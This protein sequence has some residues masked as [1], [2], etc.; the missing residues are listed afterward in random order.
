MKKLILPLIIVLSFPSFAQKVDCE[1]ALFDANK[2]YEIGA[3]QEAIDLITPCLTKHK[4]DKNEIF[5]AHRLLTLCHIA[6]NEK[7]KAI[8]SAKL[9]LQENP[10]YR[11]YPYSDPKSLTKL[12]DEFDV[13]NK[14]D[15]GLT[16]GLYNHNLLIIKSYAADKT[17]S[18][19]NDKLGFSAGLF[20]EYHI[21]EN[22]AVNFAPNI[23]SVR[24]E[25]VLDTIAGSRKEFSE[26]LTTFELPIAFRSYFNI[27]KTQFYAQVG[28]QSL[29]VVQSFADVQS[30]NLRDGS[31]FQ[32]ST[33]TTDY[34]NDNILGINAA[35][36]LT[37]RL[38]EGFFNVGLSYKYFLNNVVNEDKRYDNVDFILSSQ[39]I[40]SDFNF[41]S[42]GLMFSYQFPIIYSVK[43][44]D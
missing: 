34:R 39:Y 22:F 29:F 13:S 10:D 40:D 12:L 30:I 32:S 33:E 25:R 6:L 20:A 9:M 41:Q 35:V 18:T 8:K 1:T 3:F 4:L 2:S 23:A 38:G 27:K 36:G 19:Y 14:L 37:R 21:N 17:T 16:A 43:H 28:A 7:D 15:F 5:D 31:T 24:Y 26:I 11:L 42:L 44:Q